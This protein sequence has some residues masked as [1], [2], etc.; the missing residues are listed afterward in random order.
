[1]DAEITDHLSS[2]ADCVLLKKQISIRELTDS[3]KLNP[4]RILTRRRRQ[5]K[6][7]KFTYPGGEVKLKKDVLEA[8]QPAT[9]EADG[10]QNTVEKQIIVDIAKA[11]HEEQTVTGVVLQPEVVDSQGD[12][13][14]A[15]VI[16]ATAFK[17]LANFNKTT[18]LGVQHSVFKKGRL[19]LVESFI[20]PIDM[21]LGLKTV[22]A[23][24][25]VMTVK[26]LDAR[27]W[28][29]VKDGLITGFSIGGKAT[30][31]AVA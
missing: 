16:K 10:E 1:M 27:L 17:F 11:D 28:K 2:I 25:W 18:K 12:I 22:K 23:G 19:E 29:R 26:V 13:M 30:V 8:L 9:E 4:G 14:S 21:V 7:G 24:S 15:E 3:G 31:V 6:K 20:A 5:R